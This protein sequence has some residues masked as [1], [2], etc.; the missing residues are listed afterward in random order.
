MLVP[1]RPRTTRRQL[2][3]QDDG[4]CRSTERVSEL[5]SPADRRT[6]RLD[7]GTSSLSGFCP[8]ARF[9]RM[10]P[11]TWA[12]DAPLETAGDHWEPL[13]SE[14]MWTKPGPG[15]LLLRR[16][17]RHSSAEL[18]M[19]RP[20][21]QDGR[22]AVGRRSAP[23][24][25]RPAATALQRSP[26]IPSEIYCEATSPTGSTRPGRRQS[27]SLPG[28]APRSPLGSWRRPGCLF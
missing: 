1:S 23:L 28:P 6:P 8:Q 7:P 5:V 16:K 3:G 14:G 11:A 15:R 20:A 10:A 21:L 19:F 26:Y 27:V 12:T 18:R 24:A 13:G 22:E 2:G 17:R 25:N 4:T 9:P